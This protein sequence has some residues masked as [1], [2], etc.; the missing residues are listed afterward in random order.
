MSEKLIT[1]SFLNENKRLFSTDK[2][3]FRKT[4]DIYS[5]RTMLELVYERE[6]S[7]R[8]YVYQSD[9]GHKVFLDNAVLLGIL[10]TEQDFK[11]MYFFITK[12]KV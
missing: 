3:T 6:G 2:P 10:R 4:F 8:V 11:D 9:D 12:D 5:Y 7:V 1:L